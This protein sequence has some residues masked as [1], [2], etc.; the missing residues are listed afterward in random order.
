MLDRSTEFFLWKTGGG[1]M[2][3]E[4]VKMVNLAGK[5]R[6]AGFWLENWEICKKMGTSPGSSNGDIELAEVECCIIRKEL[7]VFMRRIFKIVLSRAEDHCDH[8]CE[9]KV[10]VFF[11]C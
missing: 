5:L 7:C 1:R 2:N 4:L 3:G 8:T 9:F 11:H 6:S 10:H